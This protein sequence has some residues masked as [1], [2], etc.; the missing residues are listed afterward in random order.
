MR[1]I[2]MSGKRIS[3]RGRDRSPAHDLLLIRDKRQDLEDSLA[4]SLAQDGALVVPEGNSPD[5]L[6]WLG[7][8]ADEVTGLDVPQLHAPIV[9][10]GDD[11]ALVELKTCNRVVMRTDAL[12]AGVVDEVKDD[13]AAI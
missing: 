3:S 2:E 5:R 1:V 13:D 11:E 12:Q 7:Q 6:A 8:F 9:A 4:V 10:T